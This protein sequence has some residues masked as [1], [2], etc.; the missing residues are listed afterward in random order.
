MYTKG[1]GIFKFKYIKKQLR[2]WDGQTFI[3]K[4]A[5]EKTKILALIVHKCLPDFVFY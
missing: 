3:N 4:N 1:T 2:T 5:R